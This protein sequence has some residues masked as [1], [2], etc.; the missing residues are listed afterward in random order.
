MWWW[1]YE[2]NDYDYDNKFERDSQVTENLYKKWLT[3]EDM[4]MHIS[5]Y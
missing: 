3:D 4:Q 2:Q 1:I 5:R